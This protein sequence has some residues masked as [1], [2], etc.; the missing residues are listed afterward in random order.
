MSTAWS[1]KGD[2][3]EACSCD[4]L[5]PCISKNMTTPANRDF[6]KVT[7]GYDIQQGKFGDVDLEG[8]KFIVV[9]QSPAIMAEGNW[10]VGLIIDSAASDA[11]VEAVSTIAGGQAGGPM[12][13]LAPLIGE[14]RGVERHP[15]E[16]SV[17]GDQRSLRVPG[18]IDQTV[19]GVQ[20]A[21]QPG[22]YVCLDNTA[23]PSNK[24]LFL[25]T[26]VK[27]VIHAF[28][29][30]WDGVDNTNNG[31]FAPFDWQGEAA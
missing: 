3:V 24:R 8:V 7:L 25:A 16:F 15:V 30:D 22:S 29:I 14:F 19:E 26:A 1:I 6:C 13:G 28:G 9:A 31:H 10:A 27:N 5:C 21:S 23:H 18:M 17:D 11:Q 20:S 12:G 4:F 2:Y